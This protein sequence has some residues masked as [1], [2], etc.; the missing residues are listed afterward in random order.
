MPWQNLLIYPAPHTPGK[1]AIINGMKKIITDKKL[2]IMVFLAIIITGC[3]GTKLENTEVS[4]SPS[5]LSSDQN[6]EEID[7]NDEDYDSSNAYSQDSGN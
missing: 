6:L 4:P 7:E 1:S 2:L 3:H 5:G